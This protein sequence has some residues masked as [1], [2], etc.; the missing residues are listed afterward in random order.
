MSP[1]LLTSKRLPAFPQREQDPPSSRVPHASHHAYDLFPCEMLVLDMVWYCGVFIFINDDMII[2]GM[3]FEKLRRVDPGYRGGPDRLRFS[4]TEALHIFAAVAVLSIAF[5]IL[6]IRGGSRLSPDGVV[7]F[8]MLLLLAGFLVSCSFLTH[9]LGHKYVAQY[10]GAWSEFR[11]YPF[12][13]V[14]AVVFSYMG[15]LF[16]APGAVYIQGDID[17]EQY[18]KISMAGPMMNFIIGAFSIVAWLM[19]TGLVSNI[20]FQLAWLNAFLGLFN[21]IPVPPLDGSKIISWKWQVF[22]VM[23]AVGAAQLAFLYL[24]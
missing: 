9:E 23:A 16:A 15:F 19:T 8:L 2:P 22:A 21:M 5:A 17:K 6:L 3:D 18:G 4:R 13:L 11:A 14:M 10:Y 1:G 7:N 12:G 24:Y 20:L